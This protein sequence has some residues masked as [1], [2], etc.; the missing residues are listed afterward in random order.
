MEKR[1]KLEKFGFDLESYEKAKDYELDSL[2]ISIGSS[3]TTLLVLIL[4]LFFGTKPLYDFLAGLVENV[5]AIRVGYILIF[6]AGFFFLDLPS[7]W[8]SYKLEHRYDLSNQSPMSWLTDQF[9]GLLISLTLALIGFTILFW[10]IAV[11]EL[12]WV[13]AW[14][15]FTVISIFIGFISP[16]LLMP[17]FYDFQPLE[18]EELKRRLKELAN[19]AQLEVLG[20]FNM[21]ASEKTK[22]AIGA[23]T[24]IGSSRRIILSDTMLENYS[25][26]EIEAVIAHEMGHHKFHDIWFLIGVQS[27]FSLLGFYLIATFI[28][29]VLGSL[30]LEL[31]VSA[32]PVILGMM[33]LILFVLSPVKNW[34]S[35]MRERAADGFSLKLVDDPKTLGE[36]LVKLSQ[37]NLGNPAPSK[38]VE[39]LFYD[40]PS[41]LDR[42]ERAFNYES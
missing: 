21:K 29:P 14:I 34:V 17:L 36:A 16:T 41:G 40:H 23:L 27:L 8:F 31:N 42:V 15:A 7:G 33:E 13:W 2:V 9:K 22:K 3:I 4:F 37:Q 39:W 5:W 25:V 1:E 20:V 10:T 38:L 28:D 11:T 24:G 12:W 18:K 30:S 6:S 35:R 19:R 26:E 32:L